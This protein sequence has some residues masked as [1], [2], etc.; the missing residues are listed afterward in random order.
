MRF[1]RAKSLLRWRERFSEIGIIV[2]GVL[3]ALFLEQLVQNWEWRQKVH[4][5]EEA[6]KREIFWDDGPQMYQRASIQPCV[7]AQLDAI[8]LAVESGQDRNVI[9]ELIDNLYVP[10][11]TYDT[12]AHEN[13]TASDVASHMKKDRVSLWTQAYAMLPMVDQASAMESAN[14]ARLRAFK[15]SGRSVSEAEEMELLQAVEAVRNDGRRMVAG[16]SWTM[17]VM[18]KLEGRLDPTRLANFMRDARKHYGNCVR[19]L[20]RDWPKTPLPRLPEGLTPGL[21][22]ALAAK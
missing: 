10:F 2:V 15:R 4:A 7:E 13:A 17:T 3:I 12:V 1:R 22:V 8:R 9:T 16:I 21:K 19:E 6:M 11:L 14:S 5:A 18:P 20:P